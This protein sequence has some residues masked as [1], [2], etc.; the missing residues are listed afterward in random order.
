MRV[1]KIRA[2]AIRLRHCRFQ[3]AAGAVAIFN[4]MGVQRRP[5]VMRGFQE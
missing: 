2:T 5:R 1:E 4:N 3:R